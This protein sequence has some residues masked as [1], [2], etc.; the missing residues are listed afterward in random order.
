MKSNYLILFM[1]L[2]GLCGFAQTFE[3]VGKVTEA[4]SGLPIPGANVT[5]R[6][7]NQ[8]T[9]TDFDGNFR[10]S[11]LQAG[12][13][14]D[15]TYLGFAP[16]EFPVTTSTDAAAISLREDVSTLEEVV[17]IGYGT[18][19]RREITGA[20]SVVSTET[21]ETL[22]PVRVE[23]ALQGTVS[24][25]QVTTQSGAPGAP[26]DI[27]I[28]GIATN[29]ENRPTTIIDG[30]VGEFATLSPTDIESITVLKD[31][32]AAIYGTIGANGVILVT[33]KKGKRNMKPVLSYNVYTGFQE[34]SR[35][36]RTLNATEYALILNESY[37]NGGEPLPFPNVTTLG[38][39]TNWQEEVFQTAVPIISHDISMTGGSDKINYAVSGSHLDQEG[40]VGGRKAGFLRNTA[41]IALGADI[42]D[43]LKL[44]TN[45]TYTYFSRKTLNENALG[46]VLFNALNIPSIFTPYDDEGNYTLVPSTTGYGTEIINPLAQ[47]DNTYNDYDFRRLS[48][49]FGLDYKLFKG[50][51]VTGRMGFN[52]SNSEG[53]TFAMQVDYG[54][55]IYDVDRSS[56]TQS[57]IN[58]NNYTFDL[59]ATYER[60]LG[61]NHNFDA[62]IGTTIFKEWGNGLFAT[63]FDVPYNSWEYADIKLAEGLSDALTNAAYAYD[64]RRLSY[65]GRIQYN[66]AGRY[67]LSALL[68]RDSSTKFGPE[69]RVGYFPSATAGWVVSK[70]NFWG[71]DNV[72]NMLKFRASYGV[73]GNDQIEN[74]RYVG[75]LEGEGTYLFDGTMI[76]GQA[77]GLTP[78]PFIQWEEARKFDVGA[79]IDLFD[80]KVRIVTDYFIDVRNELLIP[81]IPVSG[82]IGAEAPGSGAPTMNAGT[83][84]N[85][86]VEFSITYSDELFDGFNFSANYNVALLK[87]K[88]LEVDNGPGFIEGGGFG[89]STVPS[90]MEVGRPLGYFYGLQTDGIFQNAA[91]VAAHPSQSSLGAEAQPGDL[92][93][94][95]VNN[96]GVITTD[97]RTNIGDPIP[98]ATMGFTLNLDY[99][100]FD[101]AVFTYASIGN[102]MVRAYERDV[103]RGNRLSYVLDRWTGEGT[104]N[105]VPRVTTAATG[106]RVFSDYFVEDASYLRIQNIQ[107][108]YSIDPTWIS[109]AGLTKARIYVAANN[110]YTFTKYMGYDPGASTGAPIGGG[111]DYGFYPVPRT[112]MLGANINF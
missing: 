26:L 40:I 23:Q 37:A 88:V 105:Y 57:A 83:V 102:D 2:F 78:N 6:G 14:L 16:T 31:A 34:T 1:L 18:Q 12:A 45:A 98:S 48:G 106:N 84:K 77:T 66:Y 86:G 56:V 62:T 50:L 70:E 93:F 36:L 79:D 85:Y 82:I 3:V 24:G 9:T 96:D 94:V 55:K 46:S 74:N 71:T 92:R 58:D 80:N 54:V 8:G 52:T 112:Y 43:R 91:E 60:T 97:D 69:N 47:I 13:V 110:L 27:R 22:R 5:V 35:S 30:F 63:G 103:P 76:N 33:T 11:G 111:V 10:L 75:N 25:V 100:N 29:G 90:R 81:R 21:L 73:L 67:L 4:G 44:N 72:I 108:G 104:S 95:D 53:R 19:D 61:D 49:T 68:R 109:K 101:F 38:K 65:F 59:F 89:L 87:N 7:T 28:R 99:K 39:G 107:L 42:S 51:T 41:R 32:Q 17:V 15:I 20:V 64:E